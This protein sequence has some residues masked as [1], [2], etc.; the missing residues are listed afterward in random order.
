LDDF[1]KE[2]A[3]VSQA[4]LE[5]GYSI[6]QVGSLD[7]PAIYYQAKGQDAYISGSALSSANHAIQ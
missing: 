3:T 6:N 7:E 4:P 1:K 2:E 5:L